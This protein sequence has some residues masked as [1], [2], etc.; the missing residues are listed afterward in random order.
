MEERQHAQRC[1]LSVETIRQQMVQDPSMKTSRVLLLIKSQ[2]DT[3]KEHINK[4]PR[5]STEAV[6]V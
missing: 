1:M 2:L 6:K 4:H 3:L 5:F